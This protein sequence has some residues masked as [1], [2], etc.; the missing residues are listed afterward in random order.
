[1]CWV[2]ALVTENSVVR[3]L[4]VA[5]DVSVTVGSKFTDTLFLVNMKPTNMIFYIIFE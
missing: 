5:S 2:F 4:G 3:H 1:M